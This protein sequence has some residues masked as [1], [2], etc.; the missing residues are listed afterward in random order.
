MQDRTGGV[1]TSSLE[2]LVRLLK[3]QGGLASGSE[4]GKPALVADMGV[5]HKARAWLALLPIDG[6]G[7]FVAQRVAKNIKSEIDAKVA[8]ER[9]GSI[10][11]TLH[12]AGWGALAAAPVA[13]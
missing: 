3:L 4:E 9:F 11:P 13:V 1:L 7:W 6:E 2:M 10:R 12:E 8:P 5:P